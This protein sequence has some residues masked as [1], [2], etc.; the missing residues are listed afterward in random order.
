[1]KIRVG[2]IVDNAGRFGR[3]SLLK[4]PWQGLSIVGRMRYEEVGLYLQRT[5]PLFE[6]VLF[7]WSY[8]L[9]SLWKKCDIVIVLKRFEDYVIDAV[10][11]LKKRGTK[12]IFDANVNYY[13]DWG[14]HRMPG[15]IPKPWQMENAKKMT[16]LADCVVADSTYLAEICRR[17]NKNI[18]WIPDPIDTEMYKP[19]PKKSASHGKLRLLW[20]GIEWKAYH[21]EL[22]APV[23]EKLKSSIEL[24]MVFDKIEGA[25]RVDVI[26]R[27]QK[28]IGAR[29]VPFSEPKPFGRQRILFHKWMDQADVIISP[30]ILDCAYE[31]GHTE[32][33]ITQGMAAGLPALASPQ[34]SYKEALRDNVG[35]WICSSPEEWEEHLTFFI[36]DPQRVTQIGKDARTRVLERYSIPV[37]AKIYEGIILQT[38]HAV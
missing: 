35:G 1:M 18:V 3:L 37:I 30:K 11:R 19:N 36:K 9:W 12:V 2:W 22:I 6:M 4:M 29:V 26:E 13:E 21:L 34:Q 14:N 20:S 28:N 31:M 15:T 24:T 38:L 5:N 16:S 33:K 23:L 10:E 32:L 17:Y 25:P 7:D 27:L 8:P